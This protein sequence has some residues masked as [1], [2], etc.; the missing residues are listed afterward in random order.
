[1]YPDRVQVHT[2][3]DPQSFTAVE[4][5]RPQGRQHQD[6]NPH[7][8]LDDEI[9]LAPSAPVPRQKFSRFRQKRTHYAYETI[10]DHDFTHTE[11]MYEVK[12]TGHDATTWEPRDNLP[13]NAVQRYHKRRRVPPPDWYPEPQ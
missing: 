8:V 9:P 13:F 5:N 10:V 1:M 4:N 11:P 3:D 7:I 12:W 2:E 6:I